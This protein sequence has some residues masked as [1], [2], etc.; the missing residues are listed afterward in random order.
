MNALLISCEI[1]SM[2]FIIF[3]LGC[4]TLTGQDFQFQQINYTIEEGLPSN[5]CHRVLQDEEGYIWI[6]T[7]RGLVRYDG[8]EFRTYGIKEGL[9]DLS[10][11]KMMFDDE[12]KLWVL[13]L[14]GRIFISN[15]GRDHFTLFEYQQ[16]LD[17]F[18]E[19]LQVLDFHIDADRVLT[20]AVAGI[21]FVIITKD[22]EY[23]ADGGNRLEGHGLYFTKTFM[24]TILASAVSRGHDPGFPF[25]DLDR[26]KISDDQ[27]VEVFSIEH[28]TCT[29]VNFP[30]QYTL[31][32]I[33]KGIQIEDQTRINR[34]VLNIRGATFFFEDA[35]LHKTRFST[36]VDVVHYNSE[37]ISA[38]IQS[39]GLKFCHSYLDLIND[40]F[41]KQIP[42]ISVTDLL[43]DNEGNL[44]MS[45]LSN[46]VYYL[47]HQDITKLNPKGI[48]SSNINYITSGS[49]GLYFSE[50]KT[51]LYHLDNHSV[52]KELVSDPESEIRM[53]AYS[54]ENKELIVNMRRS[55]RLTS[56]HEIVPIY[57]EYGR[58]INK[59]LIGPLGSN[60]AI[61]FDKDDI[62]LATAGSFTQFKNLD[63]IQVYHSDIKEKDIRVLCGVRLDVGEYLLGTTSGL[64]S[65]ENQTLYY[66]DEY[67][68]ELYARINDIV[69][70][71][72]S[73]LYATQGYVLIIWDLQ[74]EYSII[75]KSKGLL[76]DNLEDLFVDS[77]NNVYVS[78]NAGLSKLWYDVSGSLKIKN[79]TTR[80]G[81]PSNEVNNVTEHKDTIYIATNQGIGVLA[82]E[83]ETS[84]KQIIKI[85]GCSVNGEQ[86]YKKQRLSHSENN[87]HVSYITLDY[88]MLSKI[89]YR[90]RL[91]EDTWTQTYAS[92]TNFP[93][94]K[95]G[96][97]TFQVQSQNID[98]IWSDSATWDLDIAYPWWRT[99]IFYLLA[100]LTFSGIGLAIY[101]C[102]T[103]QLKDQLKVESEIRDL[104]RS[105]LQAQM[106]P[107]FIFNCLNSIQRYIMDNDKEQAMEYLSM[108]AKLIRQS[109]T[110]STKNKITLSDEISMLINYLELEKLR[111]KNKF[112]FSIDL[113]SSVVPEEIMLPP[114]LVQ[115]YVENAVIHGMKNKEE[116]GLID[117][118]FR[119]TDANYLEIIVSDNGAAVLQPKTKQHKSLGISITSQRLAYNNEI[120]DKSLKIIPVHTKKGTTVNIIVKL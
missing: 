16:V 53:L 93:A 76:S 113:A 82:G 83:Q 51:T 18:I 15:V 28:E 72:Q 75:D 31:N 8:Y 14:S 10:C 9:L 61:W 56:A 66:S 110:A 100:L 98:G 97:Y 12:G 65:F 47:R 74:N 30:Y 24:N 117:I 37:Y 118:S 64:V 104:E 69:K 49:Q 11:L 84:D 26:I 22:G 99:K 59:E 112:E 50:N 73:Y 33:L 1:L 17:P 111:F 86:I 90:Y 32:S 23:I 67:P 40:N 68:S 79:Y 58:N 20:L 42:N 78:S 102:R 70:F 19:E 46:G 48:K 96:R 25:L 60:V 2:V 107:H 7:D 91:N 6:A 36:I 34:S 77:N 71:G 115:P 29:V 101:K 27:L 108:F 85:D 35:Q 13:T 94:L 89:P 116:D 120:A 87:F 62:I 114:L 92:S 54:R 55:C 4:G 43:E 3:L 63:N 80:N 88:K 5:E 106:N 95:P 109:L 105:A 52:A 38:E 103:R 81:L 21:G 119:I 44:W 41:Y 39:K 45:T 57:Y